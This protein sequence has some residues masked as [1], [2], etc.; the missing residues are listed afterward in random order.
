[1]IASV[2]SY[3]S[4][5]VVT[6]K[7]ETC[8]SYCLDSDMGKGNASVYQVFSGIEIVLLDFKA[9]GYI[10]KVSREVNVLEINHCLKGRA[11][12]CMADGC[13]QYIGEGDLFLNTL[14]NHSDSIELP[15]GYYKGM[16]III[17]VEKAASEMEA[18]L[19]G[20]PFKLSGL[21]NRFF[22]EDECFLI[23]V[24]DEIERLFFDMYAV[25]EEA[26]VAY[27]RL[28]VLELFIYLHYFEP[29][30]EKQKGIYGRQQVDIVKRVQKQ[31]T[32]NLSCRYTIEEMAQQ[33]CISP[34]MLKTYFKGVYG[35]PMAA[36][37]KEYRIRR[38]AVLL[39]ETDDSVAGIAAAVG[40]ESQ[41]KFGA[42]FKEIMEITPGRYRA[43]YS[44]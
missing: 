42:A 7:N 23:Q 25:P 38:A 15:L 2:F 18:R 29:D 8:V 21:M 40:Y 3:F 33:F 1:M 4:S 44:G 30:L 22:S 41:S 17:D 39:R 28:K 19:F 12:C 13:L 10:T 27:Y 32:E 43:R 31:M 35:M 26:R 24:K 20:V 16:V 37:M 34:T 11:E 6:E 5:G 14:H 36:Y 9:S